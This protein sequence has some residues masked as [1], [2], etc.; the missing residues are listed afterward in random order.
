MHASF[1]R[2]SGGR[3]MGAVL[4][5]GSVTLGWSSWAVQWLSRVPGPIPDQLQIAFSHDRK[6]RTVYAAQAAADWVKFLQSRAVELRPGRRIVIVTMS[7]DA[8]GDFGYRPLLEALYAG[9]QG[10]V[11][12]GTVRADEA[13]RMPIPTVGRSLDDLREPFAAGR[14]PDLR[15]G[16]PRAL[17]GRRR[18]LGRLPQE[19]RR[20]GLCPALGRFH[21]GVGV[22]DACPGDNGRRDSAARRAMFSDRLTDAVVARVQV[23]PA[24]M[25]IPLARMVVTRAN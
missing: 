16:R 11:Q 2:P 15:P 21:P 25:K 5:P 24:P 10:L 6:A 17:H 13:A 18:H 4:P 22:S 7:L 1:R 14:C 19:R 8:E 12:S 3:S 23:D 20:R 9:V